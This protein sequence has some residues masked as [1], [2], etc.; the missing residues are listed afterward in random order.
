MTRRRVKITERVPI[1]PRKVVVYTD[2]LMTSAGVRD[3]ATGESAKDLASSLADTLNKALVISTSFR[4]DP[5]LNMLEILD[6][7]NLRNNIKV[8]GLTNYAVTVK[9]YLLPA[10]AHTDDRPAS[11][12]I[13][14]VMACVERQLGPVKIDELFV[15]FAD[16]TNHYPKPVNPPPPTSAD[17][18]DQR[19]PTIRVAPPNSKVGHKSALSSERTPNSSRASSSHAS[20][21]TSNTDPHAACD[22]TRYLKVWRALNRLKRTGKALKI[23][24]CDL[25]KPQLEALCEQSG[26]VPDILQV[27]VANDPTED[28][29]PLDDSLQKLAKHHDISIRTH[30]D[31]M[32]ILSDDTF[33]MLATDFR[34]N[35]RFPT[36]E[37]P[38]QG[39]KIDVMKP[40]W[41]VNYNVTLK[42]RGLVSNRG[43]IAMASSDCV[44]DPNRT[45]RTIFA[46]TAN[47][48]SSSASG[49]P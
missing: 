9:M 47:S 44:L 16:I 2:N 34:I 30:S 18:E 26:I 20:S 12:Y 39:Y 28:T 35:E 48:S 1:T 19:P 42:S 29:N 32:G 31:S 49:S 36:T 14:Q 22:M 5:E 11:L 13:R 23:G 21:A 38:P 27:H 10:A 25:S 4:F 40:R 33:Q 45:S 6:P 7:C 41:V 24:I 3:Q 8:K 15:S 37:V 43:Y 17:R 46:P